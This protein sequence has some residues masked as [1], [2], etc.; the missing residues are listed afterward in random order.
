MSDVTVVISFFEALSVAF[1]E[2]LASTPYHALG[3]PVEPVCLSPALTG[4]RSVD[5]HNVP[6]ALSPIKSQR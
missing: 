4:A 1:R 5:Q 3:Y 6:A 2:V